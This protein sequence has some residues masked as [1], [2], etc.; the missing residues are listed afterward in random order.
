MLQREAKDW[1]VRTPRTAALET[2]L[3]IHRAK[4][5]TL[6]LDCQSTDTVQLRIRSSVPTARRFSNIIPTKRQL[7]EIPRMT[8][9]SN[10]YRKLQKFC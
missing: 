2:E 8:S 4:I 7:L 5:I 1:K 10:V 6:S 3:T 9:S